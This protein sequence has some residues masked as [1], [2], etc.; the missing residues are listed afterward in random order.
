V[1]CTP[2]PAVLRSS[3]AN[4]SL[5]QNIPTS[6]LRIVLVHGD[7]NHSNILIDESGAICGIVDWEFHSLQ[8]AILGGV[9]LRSAAKQLVDT[10][11]DYGA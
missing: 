6:L 8:P 5:L 2:T 1:A 4:Y 11:S 9:A 3:S 10:T 7:P